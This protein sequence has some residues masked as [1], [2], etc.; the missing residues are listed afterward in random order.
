MSPRKKKNEQT[1]LTEV[2][3]ELMN[4]LW[5]LGSGTVHEVMERLSSERKLAYTT[6]STMLRILEQK[7]F[8][9]SQAEGRGHRYSPLMSKEKYETLSLDY[10]VQNVFDGAPSSLIKRLI[11]NE[12]IKDS[13][14]EELKNLIQ[15]RSRT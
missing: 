13:D 11:D 3:L 10:L 9:K 12:L 15:E 7:G 14:L 1:K 8:V 4:L 6:V 2:E 5:K